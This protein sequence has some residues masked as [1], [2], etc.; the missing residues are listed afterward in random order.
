MKKGLLLLS[1]IAILGFNS[2]TEVAEALDFGIP[3]TFEEQYSMDI[4]DGSPNTFEEVM[5]IDATGNQ[6]VKDNISN[7]SKFDLN[8]VWFTVTSFTGD[9]GITT[10][11]IVQFY[12]DEGNIGNPISTGTIE[13]KKLVDS[14]DETIIVISNELKTTLEGKLLDDQIF[15]MRLSGTVSGSPMTANLN[16]FVTVEA[17]V[18]F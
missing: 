1:A 16:V 10:D 3:I 18:T 11:A 13:F 12:N 9:E 5:V 15:K 2:C 7:I 4:L 8:K 6:D 17:K 14:G